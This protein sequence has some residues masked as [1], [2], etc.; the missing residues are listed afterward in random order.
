MAAGVKVREPQGKVSTTDP[1]WL[2]RVA[3]ALGTVAEPWEIML[4]TGFLNLRDWIGHFHAFECSLITTSPAHQ[5]VLRN[6]SH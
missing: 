3:L 5:Q 1:L 6:A 4:V 2:T